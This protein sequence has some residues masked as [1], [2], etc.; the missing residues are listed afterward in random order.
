MTKPILALFLSALPLLGWP[1][2]TAHSAPPPASQTATPP[3]ALEVHVDELPED[4]RG[5]APVIFDQVRALVEDGGFELTDDVDDATVLRVRLRLMEAGDRNYGIHF[6]FVDGDTVEAAVEWTDCVFCTEARMLQKLDSVK[7]DLLAAIEARQRLEPASDSG[8]SGDELGDDEGGEDDGGV[9]TTPKPIGP[10]GFA[11]TAVSVLGIGAVIW[12]AVEMSR[13]RVYDQP[14]GD[15]YE[16]TGADHAPRGYALL[17]V[18]AA[19]TTAGL[20]MLGVD[21]GRRAKQRK[22]A[23]AQALVF[24]LVSPTG[25]SLGVSGSF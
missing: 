18:G 25:F 6:E 23:R 8:D 16:R 4:E 20:V 22:Q 1:L 9:V 13:G 3:V 21:L 24:P 17:G 14:A 2:P 5:V 11:G 15:Y 7:P 19:V 12:G 10:L